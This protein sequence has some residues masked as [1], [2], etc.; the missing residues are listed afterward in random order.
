M[1]YTATVATKRMQNRCRTCKNTWY[2]RGKDLSDRCPRCGGSDVTYNLGCAPVIGILGL[3]TVVTS[4][5]C[6]GPPQP[7]RTA[8][9]PSSAPALGTQPD[10]IRMSRACDVWRE[11]DG[12]AQVVRQTRAGEVLRVL[13]QNADTT[14]V[15]VDGKGSWVMNACARAP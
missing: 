6:G 4:Y 15:M 3:L 7:A 10:S 9:P 12:R 8:P 1:A 2:P 13:A 5:V 11:V 14:G